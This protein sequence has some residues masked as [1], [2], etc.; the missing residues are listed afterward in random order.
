MKAVLH[1]QGIRFHCPGCECEHYVPTQGTPAWT[2]N[3]SFDKPTLN[4]SVR[5]TWTH[6]EDE[7]KKCCH[8]VITDGKIAFC[9]DSTH[10]LSGQTV[11]LPEV[12]Q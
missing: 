4:P 1:E 6:G 9:S 8:S 3:N 12:E 2:F 11:D 7:V 5:V 10:H